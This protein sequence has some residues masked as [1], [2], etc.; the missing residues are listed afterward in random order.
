MGAPPEALSG[1]RDENRRC[2]GRRAVHAQVMDLGH[3][4]LWM[5]LVKTNSGL[6]WGDGCRSLLRTVTA[7]TAKETCVLLSC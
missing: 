3:D 5:D 4:W 1:P 6:F 7:L 2:A